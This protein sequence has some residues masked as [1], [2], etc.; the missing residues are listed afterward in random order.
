MDTK[1][2]TFGERLLGWLLAGVGWLL[3]CLL[4]GV[5]LQ[6]CGIVLSAAF[7]MVAG[8]F[9]GLVDAGDRHP[10]FKTWLFTDQNA[11][12]RRQRLDFDK[13][14]KWLDKAADFGADFAV[15]QWNAFVAP[16]RV[17]RMLFGAVLSVVFVAVVT[18]VVGKVLGAQKESHGRQE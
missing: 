1:P 3:V 7:G 15:E 8:I 18:A 12:L 17:V 16:H 4:V 5:G 6:V 9:Y 2:E 10:D 14:N 13:N 11:E